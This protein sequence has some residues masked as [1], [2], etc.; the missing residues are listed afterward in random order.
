VDTALF[1][2]IQLKV[3][4][5]KLYNYARSR[6]EDPRDKTIDPSEFRTA[7]NFLNIY[8][9]DFPILFKGIYQTNWKSLQESYM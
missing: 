3:L 9:V 4:T 7:A 5:D 8:E 1:D 6:E 2:A